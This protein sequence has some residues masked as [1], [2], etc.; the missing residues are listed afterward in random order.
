[1]PLDTSGVYAEV[2]IRQAWLL[3]TM[4]WQ[5]MCCM[6][7]RSEPSPNIRT[8]AVLLVSVRPCS[9]PPVCGP[10]RLEPKKG[11]KRKKSR[12][13]LGAPCAAAWQPRAPPPPPCLQHPRP[14]HVPSCAAA[15]PP[16]GCGTAGR[17][18]VFKNHSQRIRGDTSGLQ[19]V[20][21]LKSPCS[22][23]EVTVASLQV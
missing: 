7:T 4:T 21:S 14:P 2:T 18:A 1:M 8:Q 3:D 23:K 20:G 15:P 10:C 12:H 17:R 16:C 9:L 19:D 11:K 6:R 22:I 13:L 5:R